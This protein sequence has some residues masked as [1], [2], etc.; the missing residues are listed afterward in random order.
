[1]TTELLPALDRRPEARAEAV[2]DLVRMTRAGRIRIPEFQRGL[3]WN[4]QLVLDLFDSIYRG[5]PIGSLLFFKR[6]APAARVQLGPLTIDAPE[7]PDAYWVVDGQQ[8]L[9]AL[10][11]SMTR[12]EP[13]PGIPIDPFIVYF[14]PGEQRFVGPSR[15]G[16]VPTQWVPATLL[17]DATRLS[18]W[19]F[20]WPHA[21][22]P[23][24]RTALFEAGKR[25]REYRVPMYVLDSDEGDLLKEIFFRI[26]KSGKP[27]EWPDVYDALYGHQGPVPSSIS[28]L[29]TGLRA[30]GMGT[31]GPDELTSCLL[32]LRGLDVTRT[33]VEHRRRDPNVL[34]G[35][36]AD[37]LPV[38]RQVLSFLRAN[39]S[40]PH[41]RLLPRTFVVEVL[42][43]FFVLHPEPSQR[44]MNLLA[45]WVWR[46][47]LGEG[48]YDE[49]TLRRRSIADLRQGDEDGSVQAL[50]RLVPKTASIPVWPET[51]DARAAR[52]RLVLLG[53]ASLAPR[54]LG[55][56][57][58]IDIAG[59]IE[60][61]GADAFRIVVP[62]RARSI[63]LRSPANRLIWAGPGSARS[64][65][66]EHA[67][68]GDADEAI[69][70]SHGI[71]PAAILAL[72]EGRI[73][74]FLEMRKVVIIDAISR[75]GFRLAGWSRQDR[76]RPSIDSLLRRVG[77][78]S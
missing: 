32:A 14:H 71:T 6:R 50:L 12:P 23:G 21:D 35:A 29:A 78:T 10:A 41:L 58:I 9:T 66:L 44:N 30:I 1:M 67:T 62:V 61:Q 46:V 43:R 42:A 69:L 76:D 63:R 33:L 72:A 53:L 15:T 22:Q 20:R 24:W 18:E 37:A 13:I 57:V 26:N 48:N 55:D 51:F 45:R 38:L 27:L 64:P 11:A 34:R 31:L 60:E 65:L 70:K 16:I 75:T 73:A 49:R 52:T 74:D 5:Y 36:V 2:E 25:I 77:R 4:A 7:V 19:I 56:G 68:L 47:F 39:A 28:Q 8:R 40:V 54:N 59:L 17:L 3:K